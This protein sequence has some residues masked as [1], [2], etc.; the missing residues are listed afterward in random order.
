MGYFYGVGGFIPQLWSRYHRKRLFEGNINRVKASTDIRY[1]SDE[2]WRS[3]CFFNVFNS[4]GSELLGDMVFA[5]VPEVNHRLT[6]SFCTD[7]IY[8]IINSVRGA[9]PSS[10]F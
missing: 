4:N 1:R 8:A 5:R 3:S 10:Y 7:Y 6:D 2:Y 9:F